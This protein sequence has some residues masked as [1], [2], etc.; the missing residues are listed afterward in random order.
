MTSAVLA[1]CAAPPPQTLLDPNDPIPPQP[2]A[3]VVALA[4]GVEY[5]IE[6]LGI[7]GGEGRMPFKTGEVWRA[8][9][10]KGEGKQRAELRIESSKPR[11]EMAALGFASRFSYTVNAVIVEGDRSTPITAE[12]YQHTAMQG[13][14]TPLRMA[15]IM[16]FDSLSKQ[17]SAA[18]SLAPAPAASTAQ[19]IRDLE[20]LRRDKLITEEEY[21]VRRQALLQ[22]L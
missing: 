19:R 11:V 16:A 6:T 7:F 8:S 10:P 17:A 5:R 15:M 1:G 14:P 3:S 12:G 20:A 22:E 4:P 2:I 18:L 13:P 21:R 9:F